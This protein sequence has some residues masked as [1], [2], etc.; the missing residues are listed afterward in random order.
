MS[1]K[2][3]EATLTFSWWP[4]VRDQRILANSSKTKILTFQMSPF[5]RVF[6]RAHASARGVKFHRRFLH[7]QPAE[8][9]SERG[10]GW[11]SGNLMSAKLN[12][13]FRDESC[14][15]LSLWVTCLYASAWETWIGVL[16][17]F[18]TRIF[19]QRRPRRCYTLGASLW[20]SQ[21]IGV[22]IILI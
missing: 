5:P 22:I 10:E 18:I 11:M 3:Q 19:F 14:N 15:Q 12:S 13:N 6:S 16:G 21:L 7:T 2:T 17:R 8:W 9:F 20:N 4:K 1:H